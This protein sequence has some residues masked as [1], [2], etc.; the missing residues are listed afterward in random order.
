MELNFYENFKFWVF[1]ADLGLQ[2]S[3]ILYLFIS[4]INLESAVEILAS[5]NVV[6]LDEDREATQMLL[7]SFLKVSG[8]LDIDPG[9]DSI[10]GDVEKI[11]TW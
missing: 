10:L 9:D 7:D 2:F 8:E 11:T 5:H 6:F 3:K 1:K 4:F